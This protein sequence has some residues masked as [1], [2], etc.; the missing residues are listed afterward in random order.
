M[1]EKGV[2]KKKRDQ[3]V[4]D[5]LVF[6]W[7]FAASLLGLCA[8]WC[9][10]TFAED[11][12]G[13]SMKDHVLFDFAADENAWRSIN[14]GVMGGI[15]SGRM[16]MLETTAVF[17]GNLS[18]E[19]NGGFASVRSGALDSD[20]DGFTGFRVRIRGDGKRYQFR[21]HTSGAF[22]GPSYLCTFDTRKDEWQEIALPF[23]KFEASFRGR[24][25]PDFPALKPDEIVTLGILIANEQEG[26]F[27]LELDWIR[28][29]M[30]DTGQ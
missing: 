13:A 17:E 20:L 19:N 11:G 2:A 21:A 15:S 10:Q 9:H 7:L 22:D 18:L 5:R 29:Y 26:D 6:V 8:A 25:L 28:A 14:D 1:P 3:N 16:R 4:Y 30:L 12:A 24:A 23:S 27:H